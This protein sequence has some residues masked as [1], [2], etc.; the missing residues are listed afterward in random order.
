M[1]NGGPA[2]LFD[3]IA[4]FPKGFRILTNANNS[5]R[6]FACTSFLK[7]CFSVKDAIQAWRKLTTKLG[8]MPP[9]EVQNGPITENMIE[10]PHIDLDLFPTPKWHSHDG[11]RYIGTGD[12]VITSDPESDRVNLGTYRMMIVNKDTL[13]GWISHGKHAALHRQKYFDRGKPCPVVVSCGHHPLFL[14]A[15]ASGIRE[16][17][18]ELEI[19]GSVIGRGVEVVRGRYTGL[20]IPAQAEIAIE[21]EFSLTETVMEGPFGEWTGYYASPSRAEPIIKVKAIYFRNDPIILGSPPSK[22]NP[23][24]IQNRIQRSIAIED[25]LKSCG[26]P[27]IKGVWLHE[28]GGTRYLLAISIKQNYPGHAKQ[29]AMA[30]LGSKNSNYV[31][32]FVIV[33]DDDIDVT[34]LN[35]V[36]WAAST[37]C[38]PKEAISIIDGFWTSPLDPAIPWEIKKTSSRAVID[39]CWPYERLPNVPQSCNITPEHRQQM[40]KKWKLSDSQ[41]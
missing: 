21:G 17:L 32:R 18:T 3:G 11:G 16:D 9:V 27:G 7:D 41:A 36:L 29:V 2:L 30:A 14:L 1:P 20:P 40:Q 12:V 13:A 4:G 10:A 38:D 19:V 22:P 15:G 8:T 26:L 23:S 37:R 35:D 31:G 28:P 39:A 33:V 34:D 5:I 25:H 6:R 24:N